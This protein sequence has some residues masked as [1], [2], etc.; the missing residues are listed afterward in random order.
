MD[1]FAERLIPK[2][3]KIS[4]KRKEKVVA[5]WWVLSIGVVSLFFFLNDGRRN[6]LGVSGS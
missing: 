2:E 5:F 6:K 4:A 3:K 1:S